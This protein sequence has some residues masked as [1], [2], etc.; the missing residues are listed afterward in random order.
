MKYL[1][2]RSKAASSIVFTFFSIAISV[3]LSIYYD[4]FSIFIC[5]LI[6]TLIIDLAY[7]KIRGNFPIELMIIKT[8]A[9]I[10]VLF[11]YYGCK[12]RYGMPYYNG[13]S[14][15]IRFE[16][17]AY[18][19]VKN[20]II[21]PW[22]DPTFNN[23]NSNGF[24]N[25]NYSGFVWLLSLLIRLSNLFG[26]Y[27]TLSFRFLNVDI[28]ISICILSLYCFCNNRNKEEKSWLILLMFFIPNA[29]FASSF[30][31]RDTLCS[32]CIILSY[33]LILEIRKKIY[34]GKSITTKI[35]LL[36]T[37]NI[38]GVFIR[39]ETILFVLVIIY[40]A[41]RRNK[42]LN[43]KKNI[44]FLVIFTIIMYICSK[45]NIFNPLI[46]KINFY[47][48]YYLRTTRVN[49][50]D[51]K[52]FQIPLIPFGWIPRIL[53]CMAF[54]SPVMVTRFDYLLSGG[55]YLY[56]YLISFGVC[57]Q[58][59]FLPYMF[60]SIND[61]DR[62]GII[63]ILFLLIISISTF[64]FRHML[65]VYPFMVMSTS[66]KFLESSNS[67]KQL[68]LLYGFSLLAISFCMYYIG[69]VI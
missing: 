27:N 10:S 7:K 55:I 28:W 36:I 51:M 3:L 6:G 50:L 12:S 62:N 57:I 17:Q 69:T 64:S 18:N 42:G 15:D 52:I 65:I 21:W 67:K 40:V 54:P 1:I 59:I 39:L 25:N 68:Y 47:Q 45:I 19:Y 26:D 44:G 58:I 22:D 46:N 32:F 38:F 13:G 56:E 63:T 33:V 9:L 34:S 53:L 35:F 43:I 5:D 48:N 29:L 61:G 4:S 41:F 8:I 23:V 49:S 60:K 24:I 16:I 66:K 14:D 11:V 37:V 30:V 31:F 2:S 20:G